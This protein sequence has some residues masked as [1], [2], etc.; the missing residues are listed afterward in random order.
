MTKF[1]SRRGVF[2][3]TRGRRACP[4][5]SGRGRREEGGLWSWDLLIIPT[6]LISERKRK[7]TKPMVI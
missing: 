4:R 5:R 7:D 6:T 2:D 1:K 3:T